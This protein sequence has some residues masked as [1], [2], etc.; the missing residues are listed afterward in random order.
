MYFPLTLHV[1]EVWALA[2]R[3]EDAHRKNVLELFRFR[4]SLSGL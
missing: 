2:C 4:D 3:S 1:L